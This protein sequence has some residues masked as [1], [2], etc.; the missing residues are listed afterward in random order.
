MHMVHVPKCISETQTI[1]WSTILW[2]T[3]LSSHYYRRHIFK[4]KR[5]KGKKG[6][7]KKGQGKR[8]G[9]MK[10]CDL[11]S[12]PMALR[13]INWYSIPHRNEA[14]P[15]FFVSHLGNSTT[16]Q[17]LIRCICPVR[18]CSLRRRSK[19]TKHRIT[20]KLFTVTSHGQILISLK[21]P[22]A[23]KNIVQMLR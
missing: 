11:M 2:S 20:Q 23:K 8:K 9:E 4:T 19:Q 22:S 21:I 5:R 3:D 18:R 12:K 16:N 1:L 7:G 10:R 17:I 6:K 13:Y 14:L 15:H